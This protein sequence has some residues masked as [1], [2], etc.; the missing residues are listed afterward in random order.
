[1]KDRCFSEISYRHDGHIHEDY[2]YKKT[3]ELKW[4]QCS[5]K[6]KQWRDKCSEKGFLKIYIAYISTHF[7]VL[8]KWEKK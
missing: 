5:D 6:T 1:M 3:K 7:R 2:I 4:F 8:T